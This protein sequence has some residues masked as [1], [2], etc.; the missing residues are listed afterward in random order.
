MLDEKDKV[1]RTH[2]LLGN[3]MVKF[4]NL[5]PAKYRIRVIVDSNRN[6]LWDSGD[7]ASQRQP[8]RVIYF[9]KTLDIRAN[10][11]FEEKLKIEN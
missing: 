4:A 1:Q 5:K 3:G 10:W 11:D 8:E 6:G 2:S 7:F 9:D